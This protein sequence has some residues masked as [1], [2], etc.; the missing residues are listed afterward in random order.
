MFELEGRCWAIATDN[1][2][3]TTEEKRLVEESGQ[4]EL[5]VHQSQS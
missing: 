5:Y 2:N 1:L 4:S 3:E